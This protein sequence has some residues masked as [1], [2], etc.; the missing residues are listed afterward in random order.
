MGNIKVSDVTITSLNKNPITINN[1]YYIY[2]KLAGI[3][4]CTSYS[5]IR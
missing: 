2:T 5:F 4:K 3:F 1:E